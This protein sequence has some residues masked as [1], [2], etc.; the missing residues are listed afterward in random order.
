M[1]NIEKMYYHYADTQDVYYNDIV[2]S[3]DK[4]HRFFRRMGIRLAPL[5]VADLVYIMDPHNYGYVTL[6]SIKKIM[7]WQLARWPDPR[8]TVPTGP[9]ISSYDSTHYTPYP[10]LQT[11]EPVQE[12]ENKVYKQP[13]IN[14]KCS[15]KL[16]KCHK[17]PRWSAL[18]KKP[19]YPPRP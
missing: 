9:T 10:H 17:T 18:P 13:I 12:T 19:N 2:M 6:D 16:K 1:K 7:V 15:H 11:F 5:Q 8:T 4:V 14:L 3:N